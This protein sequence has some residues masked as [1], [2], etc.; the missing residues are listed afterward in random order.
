MQIEVTREE[1][2]AITKGIRQEERDRFRRLANSTPNSYEYGVME[3]ALKYTM[4]RALRLR[5]ERMLRENPARAP[6]VEVAQIE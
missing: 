6:K 1:L 3:A 5:C 2:R 4:L